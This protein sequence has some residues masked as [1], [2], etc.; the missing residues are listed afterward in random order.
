MDMLRRPESHALQ[1]AVAEGHVLPASL[2]Q[3]FTHGNLPNLQREILLQVLKVQQGQGRLPTSMP[4]PPPPPQQLQAPFA[5]HMAMSPRTSPLGEQLNLAMM[6]QQQ[7]R[8]TPNSL[9]I[10]P[11]PGQQRIP[12]PQELVFH[13]QQIMQNALIKRKLEEQKENYR[14]RQEMPSQQPQ[15]PPQPQPQP[16][17]MYPQGTDSISRKPNRPETDSPLNFTPTSVIKKVVAD[18]R[19]SDVKP[20]VPELRVSSQTPSELALMGNAA[21]DPMRANNNH[22]LS[23]TNMAMRGII[24]PGSGIIPPPVTGLP[25]NHPLLMMQQQQQQMLHLAAL[26]GAAAAAGR[27]PDS[28]LLPQQPPH[29]AHDPQQPM[30]QPFRPGGPLGPSGHGDLSR[31]FSPEVLAQAQAAGA[32]TLPPLPTQQALTL[33]E[34]E[35]AAAVKI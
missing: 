27:M 28:K 10:S 17:H 3:Q 18:R 8:T 25:Q 13:T 31:F 9:A 33:E 7:R 30:L 12:S 32:S 21:M 19:D 26:R 2:L 29:F 24:P 11:T 1:L 16:Q 6:Q 20:S 5:Q 35:R 14:R 4:P 22:P 34:L 15:L 23:P